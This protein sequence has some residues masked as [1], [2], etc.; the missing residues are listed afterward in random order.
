[1]AAGSGLG[2]YEML[3]GTVIFARDGEHYVYRVRRVLSELNVAEGL[4]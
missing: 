1:M 3:Y 2:P 4:R